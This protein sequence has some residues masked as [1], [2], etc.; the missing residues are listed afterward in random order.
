MTALNYN[1]PIRVPEQQRAPRQIGR[2]TGDRV[3]RSATRHSRFVRFLRFAIP[4]VILMIAGVILAATYLNNKLKNS[5]FDPGDI[6]VSGTKVIMKSPRFT[7]FTKDGRPYEM[8]ADTAAHDIT[9]PDI[10]D[11]KDIDANVALQ[12]GQHVTVKSING[13]YDSKAEVLKLNDHIV[14]KTTSGYEGRLSEATVYVASSRIVSESPVEMKLPNGLLHAN[15]LEVTDN[16]AV[17][18]FGGG[19]ELDLDPQKT[20]PQSRPATQDSADAGT[21][22][23]TAPVQTAPMQQVTA[24]RSTL[25][26]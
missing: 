5:P 10:V 20:Q 26:P 1:L 7:G 11:L 2:K 4:V 8:T 21:P 12:D 13:V 23:Q 17:V 3:F 24:R 25:S 22:A 9:R 15:R 6:S 14:L 18:L 16:G 19:V